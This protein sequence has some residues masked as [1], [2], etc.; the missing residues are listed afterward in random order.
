M[1]QDVHVAGANKMKI[2]I[3]QVG[4]IVQV[5]IVFCVLEYRIRGVVN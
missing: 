5:Y 4:L 2:Y 3:I 1:S